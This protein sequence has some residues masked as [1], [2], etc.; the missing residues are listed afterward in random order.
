MS[1]QSK[2]PYCVLRSAATAT[3]TASG[4]FVRNLL[5]PQTPHTWHEDKER[6]NFHLMKLIILHNDAL[7]LLPSNRTFLI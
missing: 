7:L 3:A 2:S 6:H 1:N 4:L 5:L